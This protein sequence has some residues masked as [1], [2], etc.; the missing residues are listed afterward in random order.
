MSFIKGAWVV[1]KKTGKVRRLISE[2]SKTDKNYYKTTRDRND[3][4]SLIVENDFEVWTPKKDDYCWLF[5][6]GLVRIVEIN[7]YS[8]SEPIYSVREI[9]TYRKHHDVILKSLEPFFGELPLYEQDK[10]KPTKNSGVQNE[11]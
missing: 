1:E 9:N 8:D 11:I 6:V 4:L 7:E 2:E 10:N 5:L 3:Y